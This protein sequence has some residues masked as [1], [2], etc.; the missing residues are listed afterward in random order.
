MK[1]K[2]NEKSLENLRPSW[3]KGESGNAN[4]RP[5]GALG[6][7]TIAR[8]WLEVE[9]KERNNITGEDENLTQ[10]DLI[11]LAQIKKAKAGDTNAYKELL[12][13][14]YGQATQPIEIDTPSVDLSG[15]TTEEI[16][17]LLKDELLND[18][19]GLDNE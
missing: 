18:E 6:R 15:L 11:T 1:K 17:A 10:E 4:G 14:A 7:S 9:T 8:R 5:K 16:K 3:Q 12:N 19:E 2:V 13:S